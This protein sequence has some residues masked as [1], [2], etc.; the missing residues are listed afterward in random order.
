MMDRALEIFLY[1]LIFGNALL[2]VFWIIVRVI[3]S[4]RGRGASIKSKLLWRDLFGIIVGLIGWYLLSTG[5]L[6][7]W[8]I[9]FIVAT[10]LALSTLAAELIDRASKRRPND[11]T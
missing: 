11:A 8:P 5:W 10:L 6:S 7:K 2:A 1:V 9:F 3:E 4:R